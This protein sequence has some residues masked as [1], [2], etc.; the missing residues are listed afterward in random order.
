M[1]GV[2]LQNSTISK[3]DI[4]S[5]LFFYVEDLGTTIKI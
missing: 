2:V 3:Y 5:I 1:G 4:N